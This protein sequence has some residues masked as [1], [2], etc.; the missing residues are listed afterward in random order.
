M[1]QW[2]I[3][4]T[5]SAGEACAGRTTPARTLLILS[6]GEDFHAELAAAAL[7]DCGL[8]VHCLDLAELPAHGTASLRYGDGGRAAIE[9][10]DGAFDPAEID[11]VWNRRPRSARVPDS[12]ASADRGFAQGEWRQF[13]N[14]LHDALAHARWINPRGAATAAECKPA[15]LA[16]AQQVGLTVP[17]TLISNDPAAIR[18]FLRGQPDAIYKPL[19]GHVWREDGRERATYTAAVSEQQLPGDAMLRAVPG[20]LQRR[21]AKAY[22]VRAQFFGDACYAIRIESQRLPHG[23]LDWRLHQSQLGECSAIELP[24]AVADAARR[25]LQTLGLVAGGFDFIVDRA[26]HW[27]FL[28]VNQAGQFLMLER[29]CPTLPVL[30]AFCAFVRSG[31]A[32]AGA[33]QAAGAPSLA[34][35][36]ARAEAVRRAA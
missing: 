35:A 6:H 22:E 33:G 36:L 2:D 24:T 7:R 20:I 3:T 30:A 12:V 13:G 26:G 32:D 23:E 9:T 31:H 11:V 28:E 34:T 17:P 15:Q 25:L 4:R 21:V 16:A 27:H 8:R 18:A 1:Q 19:L 29:Y 5:R 14:G 10:R